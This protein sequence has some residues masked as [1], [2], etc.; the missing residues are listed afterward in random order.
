MDPSLARAAAFVNHLLV[1]PALNNLN[2]L[3]KEEQILQFLK[4]N[5]QSLVPTLTSPQFF[6]GKPWNEILKLLYTA[7]IQETDKVLK[8]QLEELIQQRI[9]FSF[10]SEIQPRRVPEE[11]CRQKMLE[12]CQRLLVKPEARKALAGPLTAIVSGFV[13]Q[14]L[15]KAFKDRQY[16]HFELTKVQRLR[17]E[18]EDIRHMIHITLLLRP[19]IQLFTEGRGGT[20]ESM[21]TVLVQPQFAANALDSMKAQLQVLPPELLRGGLFSNVSFEE[22]KQIDATA[23]IAAIFSSR[24]KNYKPISRLDRGAN[25]PD[26][27]WFSITRRN[28]KYYGFDIKML[29]EFYKIASESGW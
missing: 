17:L 11:N 14:Y 1:N 9:S 6:P 18:I 22:D 4:T 15:E 29:D 25:T 10:I 5:A 28:Y 13:G 27:S 21:E 23:R 8:P 20:G 3:Q 24:A 7:L 12:L 26:R 16:V 2:P 19:S